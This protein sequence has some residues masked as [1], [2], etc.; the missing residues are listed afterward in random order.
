MFLVT[1]FGFDSIIIIYISDKCLIEIVKFSPTFFKALDTAKIRLISVKHWAIGIEN[2][3]WTDVDHAAFVSII[4]LRTTQVIKPT[5]V[6]CLPNVVCFFILIATKF[7]W[8]LWIRTR[9]IKTHF[10]IIFIKKM[11]LFVSFHFNS[12]LVIFLFVFRIF[13]ISFISSKTFK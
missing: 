4:F 8:I 9:H 3:T 12:I 2:H 13:G 7:R 1:H 5:D 11:N 6:P 10:I